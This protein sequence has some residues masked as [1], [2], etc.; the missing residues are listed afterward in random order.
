MT[1]PHLLP[2]II[3]L[4]IG[5]A[6][7]LLVL[8]AWHLPPFSPALPQTENAYIRGRVTALAPQLS[9]VL[10][11]VPVQDFQP[12]R[13][14]DVIA[15]LDD[16]IYRQKLAQAEADLGAARARL[17]LAEQGLT[18]AQA[19]ARAQDA[20]RSAA[21]AALDTALA[22][23]HRV[24]ALNQRGVATRSSAD[25]SDLA[26]SQAQA[27]QRQAEA[28]AEVQAQAIA[29][30]RAQIALAREQIAAAQAAAELARL[31]LAHTVVTAPED[32]TLGQIQAR[33]G[34]YV[35]A[36][37]T[38]A[39][40]V[41]QDL[42]VIANFRETETAGLA[43]GARVLMQVDALGGADFTGRIAAFSPAT[44]SEFSLAA[45][46]TATGN[47]TKIAQRLPVRIALDPG[48]PRAAQL[49]PGLSTVVRLAPQG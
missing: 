22:E 10:A 12:V 36:G 37:T 43:L 9:G 6:G 29:G 3:A 25:Q 19:Q 31:D 46:S 35:A 14:G 42:W 49:A 39:S 38:L 16:R 7:L 28:Q 21:Q 33:I 20:A 27:G 34:Q 4:L 1:R 24:S 30:A 40:E 17:A 41:G 45:G 47:F 11:E 23:H 15:R 18:T 2:S 13:R 32:G 48:Q 26:L 44:A 8:F 5:L